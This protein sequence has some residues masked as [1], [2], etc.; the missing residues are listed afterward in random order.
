MQSRDAALYQDRFVVRMAEADAQH[1]LSVP[2]LAAIVQEAAGRH[3][4][5]L[6]LGVEDLGRTNQAWFLLRMFLHLERFPRVGQEVWVQTWPCGLKAGATKRDFYIRDAAGEL[7]GWASSLW[8]VVDVNARRMV[9]AGPVLATR[10]DSFPDSAVAFPGGGKVHCQENPGDSCSLR[11]RR[12]E[13]DFY[14]HV[15][16]TRI[17]EWGLEAIPA[18]FWQAHLLYAADIRFAHEARAGEDIRIWA[19]QAGAKV[20]EHLLVREESGQQVAQL[21][22][23]W[24]A[25]GDVASCV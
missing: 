10:L 25:E 3:A 6:Q 9:P 17:L 15:N 20:W 12:S 8:A 23:W 5:A 16:N 22:S 21:R 2:A 7:Y 14:G 11:A 1:R 4:S 13:V 24:R 19:G 18:S